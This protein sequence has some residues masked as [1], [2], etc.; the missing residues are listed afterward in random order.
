MSSFQ[1]RHD[2]HIVAESREQKAESRSRS[3]KQKAESEGQRKNAGSGGQLAV[4]RRQ[5]AEAERR[6]QKF[7]SRTLINKKRAVIA[8]RSFCF[9]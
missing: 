3:R 1:S 8:D 2:A 9:Y 5:N 4:G 6:G 7:H